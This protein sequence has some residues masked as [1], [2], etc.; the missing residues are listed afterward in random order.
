M[1]LLKVDNSQNWHALLRQGVI[2][3]FSSN[4]PKSEIMLCQSFILTK[5]ENICIFSQVVLKYMFG[6]ESVKKRRQ[7]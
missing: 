5:I 1:K 7:I 4:F 6:K 2:F 3:L